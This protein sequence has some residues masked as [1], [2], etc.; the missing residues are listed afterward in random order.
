MNRRELKLCRRNGK[1][2]KKYIKSDDSSKTQKVPRTAEQNLN[3]VK[4]SDI[5]DHENYV[6]FS[7]N[8]VLKS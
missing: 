2:F 1:K 8:N 3:E 6:S 4:A 7:E 5:E